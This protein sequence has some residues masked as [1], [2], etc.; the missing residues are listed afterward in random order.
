MCVLAL[1]NVRATAVVVSSGVT[2]LVTFSAVSISQ[3]APTTNGS[4][5]TYTTHTGHASNASLLSE[6]SGP[7]LGAT[8]SPSAKLVLITGNGATFAVIDGAN[9]YDLSSLTNTNGGSIM[10]LETGDLK[11]TSGTQSDATIE[12]NKT[13]TQLISVSFDDTGLGGHNLTFNLTGLA[14]YSESRTTPVALKYTD[15][16]KG[17]IS[18]MTGTG[19]FDGSPFVA[20]AT[21]SFSGKAA[22]TEVP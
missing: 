14:V 18:S 15:T 3:G 19:S 21:I 8:L 11:I 16:V 6:L 4:V 22:L 2:N 9:F 7:V 10:T 12:E 20:T 17:K 5:V 13:Q 1:S